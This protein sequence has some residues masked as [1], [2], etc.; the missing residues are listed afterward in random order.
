MVLAFGLLSPLT[1]PN[2]KIF[3]GLASWIS[4]PERPLQNLEKKLVTLVLYRLKKRA[5]TTR[6]PASIPAVISPF[7]RDRQLL[8]DSVTKF[9]KLTCIRLHDSI[10]MSCHD[11]HY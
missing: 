8:R 4:L 1:V 5:D 6:L 10:E 11:F 3:P 9:S 7:L 2:D